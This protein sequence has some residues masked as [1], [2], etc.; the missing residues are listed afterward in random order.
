MKITVKTTQQKIFHVC[1][2]LP[3]SLCSSHVPQVEVDE[4]ESIGTLKSKIEAEQSYPTA[5]QKII[6][7]GTSRIFYSLCS[8]RTLYL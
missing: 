1:S 5:S 4:T 2:H 6:Y 7:S 3:P 8:S